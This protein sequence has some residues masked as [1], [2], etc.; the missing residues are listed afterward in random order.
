M[1]FADFESTCLLIYWATAIAITE[2]HLP[3]RMNEPEFVQ[4][5][6]GGVIEWQICE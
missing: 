1:K 2:P 3:R 4:L 5:R 6:T